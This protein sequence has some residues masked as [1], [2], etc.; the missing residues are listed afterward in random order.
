MIACLSLR[1]LSP[2]ALVLAVVLAVTGLAG[3]ATTESPDPAAAPRS[4][5]PEASVALPTSFADQARAGG[6]LYGQHCAHCHGDGGEG[7]VKGP[8]VV[9]L[10]EG[11]LPLDPPAV[12]RNRTGRF[13][14]VADVAAFTIANMPP[15]KRGGLAASDYWAIL[16]FDLRANGVDLSAPLTPELAQTLTIPR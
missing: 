1:P 13:V 7:T 5:V 14:T 16:A 12:R 4:T 3:C 6:A 11:A 10:K 8:R 15:K 2:L 9:G